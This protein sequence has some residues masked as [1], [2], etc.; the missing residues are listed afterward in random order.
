MKNTI[1]LDLGVIFLY[2]SNHEET[3]K[4]IKI[5]KK[6]TLILINLAIFFIIALWKK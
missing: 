6:I 3:L 4:E 1:L 5:K 2:E